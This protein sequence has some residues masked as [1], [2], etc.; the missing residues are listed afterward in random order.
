MIRYNS[1][2]LVI[3][4]ILIVI[5]IILSEQEFKMAHLMRFYGKHS[6]LSHLLIKEKLKR[7][8]I[9]LRVSLPLPILLFVN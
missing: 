4:I 7:L 3:S 2:S 9:F 1:N 6:Q 5:L 8:Q